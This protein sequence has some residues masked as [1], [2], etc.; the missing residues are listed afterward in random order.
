MDTLPAV[1][2][3][4]LFEQLHTD[5]TLVKHS[6]SNQDDVYKIQAQNKNF[7]LKLSLN[8]TNEHDNLLKMRPYLHV[9]D[10][11]SFGHIFG[12]DHL[13]LSEVPG[14]NLAE[15]VGEWE[16][17]AIVREFAKA[18]KKFHMLDVNIFSQEEQQPDVVVL[19]GDMALPNIVYADSNSV[20][21]IDLGQIHIGTPDIDIADALWSLQRN[22]GPDYG[23][24]FLKEYGQVKMTEKLDTALRFRYL[25]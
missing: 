15:F 16:D 10:V 18:V 20:S 23:E 11:I 8:L 25:A 3:N 4:W 22:V 24:L 17:V 13:L 21:Y 19:H 7:Y 14:K 1:S 6:F 2:K 12:I 5:F 9:P